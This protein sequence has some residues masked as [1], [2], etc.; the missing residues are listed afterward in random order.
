MTT[1]KKLAL[2]TGIT[3]FVGSHLAETLLERGLEV[4]GLSR[5]RSG[6]ANIEHLIDKI[7]LAEANMLDPSSLQSQLARIKPDY[8]FH[9]AAESLVPTSYIQPQHTIETNVIGTLNL[10]QAIRH[11]GI[12]PIVLLAGSSEQYGDVEERH[13]PTTEDA[14]FNPLSPYAVSKVATD[15]LAYQ[16]YKSYGLRIIRSRAFNHEGPRRP[17]A[18]VTSYLAKEIALIEKGKK[19]PVVPV[20]NLEAR[21][22]YTDVRD[23]TRAYLLLV[24]K[25]EP[26]EAYNLSSGIAYKIGD[27][28]DLLVS[29]SGQS[30]DIEVDP[31]RLRPSDPA[32]LLGDST[33]FRKR[34]G[35]APK[36][37]FEKT[38]ADLLD[39][40]RARV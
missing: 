6:T 19:K 7:S 14:P 27:V 21:R 23:M 37:P 4:H 26:G 31:N 1:N 2:I 25:C 39:Y 32:I 9:L 13:L 22:D 15:Y 10:F 33:K 8:I 40:W 3:G 20:G 24:E 12:D 35:W 28:L 36:I 17:D 29:I 11:V 16:Y 5:W 34:T 38:M 30:V 18:F